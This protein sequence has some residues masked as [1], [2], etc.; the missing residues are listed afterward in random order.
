ME[1]R[2]RNLNETAI[3]ERLDEMNR[4]VRLHYQN[5]FYGSCRVRLRF[6]RLADGRPWIDPHSIQVESCETQ[7]GDPNSLLSVALR[8]L[9]HFAAQR[10]EILDQGPGGGAPPGGLTSRFL[11]WFGPWSPF[12]TLSS[13][14]AEDRA[15][16]ARIT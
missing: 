2:F 14:A 7:K 16:K 9:V 3:V 4:L 12:R 15:H 10:P 11:R 5:P 13:K 6:L 8:C 1:Y